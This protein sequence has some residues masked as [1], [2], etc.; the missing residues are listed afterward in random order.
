MIDVKSTSGE[1]TPPHPKRAGA[2]PSMPDPAIILPARP[3]EVYSLMTARTTNRDVIRRR[4][5]VF[6]RAISDR[7]FAAKYRQALLAVHRGSPQPELPAGS[8]QLVSPFGAP[9]PAELMHMV[10]ACPSD[11]AGLRDRALLL[12]WAVSGLRPA[13][14]VA[15]DVEHIRFAASGLTIETGGFVSPLIPFGPAPSLCPV[16]ALRDWLHTPD[17]SS[18]PVFRKIDRWG[19]IERRRLSPSAPRRM[20]RRRW[21][22][23]ID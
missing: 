22:D 23:Q 21:P 8:P 14:L 3:D 11:H 13:A 20:I 4:I 2:W 12:L 17:I 1:G 18:G 10:A 16:Q 15:L 5:D 9:T 19:N 7:A 6:C